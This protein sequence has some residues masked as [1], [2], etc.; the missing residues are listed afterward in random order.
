MAPK[1]FG[2][3]ITPLKLWEIKT[4]SNLHWIRP[5]KYGCLIV[6][7]SFLGFLAC[8]ISHKSSSCLISG[9]LVKEY[10][11]EKEQTPFLLGSNQEIN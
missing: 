1:V 10:F 9:N 4:K 7:V 3:L 5:K 11:Y 6:Y 2:F 8:P